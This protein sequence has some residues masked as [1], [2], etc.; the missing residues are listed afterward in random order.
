M[1]R[2][3]AYS[4][5]AYG[6]MITN[7]PRM[8]AYARALRQAVRPG[9]VVLDIGA[10]TGIFSLLACQ[11]GAGHVHAVEPDD[12]IEIARA[13]A[14][15]NGFADRITFHQNLSTAIALPRPADVI[16]SDLR[17]VL[18]LLQHHIPAIAD[19][20]RRLLASGGVL[21]PRRDT[22][23]A[24]LL[25]DPKLYRPHVEPWLANAY[26]L[27]LRVGQPFVVNNWRKVNAKAQQLL[28]DPQRWAI[29][30]YG[31]IEQANAGGT[32]EWTVERA[33]TAHGL[34]VWFDAELAEGIGFSNAPGQPE[35]IYGQAFFPFQEPLALG[36]GDAVRVDLRASLVDGEYVW[37]WSTEIRA[38]D[39]ASRAK[40]SFRQSTF[41]GAPIS[42]GTLKARESGFVPQP[43][44]PV[45]IDQFILSSIDGRACLSEIAAGVVARFPERFPRH[46]DAL[47]HVVDLVGKYHRP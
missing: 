35:L 19:A 32:L 29:L 3:T 24:A 9:C 20:R 23:W 41:Y 2:P 42:M 8:D 16:V 5:I 33:G 1:T 21:I 46:Q 11:F 4:V 36:P 30:D 6:D 34:L 17:S 43:G 26:G 13:A 45:Q 47:R 39:D 7:Q 15:A 27:D 31:S 37:G 22:L 18:P 10:G 12:A 28:V 25:E 14:V 44:E 38:G 40:A